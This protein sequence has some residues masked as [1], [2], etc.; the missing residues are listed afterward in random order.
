MLTPGT[1]PGV[2]TPGL[3][4]PGPVTPVPLMSGPGTLASPAPPVAG[5]VGWVLGEP[6]T[7][8][9]V[10]DYLREQAPPPALAA[11]G[12]DRAIRRWAARSLL[13]Q[14]VVRNEAARR[15]LA[16]DGDLQA[17]VATE[18]VGDGQP[19]AADVSSYLERNRERYVEPERRW[20]R[21]VLCADEQTASVVAE[22]AL[23]GERIA[24]LARQ[25]ST[26]FGSKNAGGDLGPLRRGELAG[27][28]EE[29]VFAAEADEVLGP[30]RSP[31]GW[32]VLVVYAIQDEQ[33]AELALARASI[34]A[35][36]ARR[37]RSVAYAAWFESRLLEAVTVAPGY[38]HPAQPGL[39]DRVHRH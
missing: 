38:D 36:L 29:L 25:F 19:T 21:H 11:T 30:V 22:R 15:G 14:L 16:T 32:H 26:D 8:E 35:D 12:D 33:A 24:D 13:A 18:L 1:G 6:V 9:M 3:Y 27:E 23:A 34:A 4:A 20:V 7:F 28:I 17:T 37:N 5:V 31:F 39:L 2:L 10:A